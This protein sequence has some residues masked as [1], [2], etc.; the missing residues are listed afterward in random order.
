MRKFFSV[1]FILV[2]CAV[3]VYDYLEPTEKNTTFPSSETEVTVLEVEEYYV[4]SPTFDNCY[5]AL[6]GF[7]TE[8]YKSLYAIAQEMPMGYIKVCDGDE[9]ADYIEKYGDCI[10]NNIAVAYE[11]MLNDNPEI[12]WMPSKY[13]YIIGGTETDPYLAV[14]FS[15]AE[16]FFGGYT[17]KKSERDKMR[18]ELEARVNEILNGVSAQADEYTREK[19][20]NDYIC[21]HTE[22]VTDGKLINT[23]YGCLVNGKALCEGFSRAF[24]LLC[25]ESGIECDLI[26]GISQGENHMWNIVNIDGAHSYVDVTWNS[27]EEDLRY[28]YFNI[29]ENQLRHDHEIATLADFSVLDGYGDML[30][31][32]IH[33]ECTYTGNSY[34]SKNDL[35]IYLNYYDEIAQIIKNANKKG[36]SS[37][38]VML[39][40]G[41]ANRFKEN[42][43]EC[44]YNI[45]DEL[46]GITITEYYY[47][48]DI[49]VL[50]FK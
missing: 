27:S 42:V 50:F 17:V 46:L 6:S 25:N 11:A 16:N 10:E 3:I 4:Y 28:M 13:S 24:K 12:F 31:N 30:Y 49:L 45:Q 38:T 48:R 32:F 40:E 18:S 5:K 35:I 22:Y 1:V 41:V 2:L 9:I 36:K 8:I 33:R 14:C 44:L 29:T 26:S 15:S 37:V 7:D 19:H 43:T 47:E 21:D 20:F 23:A 39:G 34:Y